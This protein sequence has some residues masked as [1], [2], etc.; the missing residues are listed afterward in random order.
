[1]SGWQTF[2]PPS[3]STDAPLSVAAPACCLQWGLRLQ[4]AGGTYEGNSIAANSRGSV[5][6]SML[7]DEVDTARMVVENKLDRPVHFLGPKE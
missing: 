7:Y 3:W 4:D 6:C 2:T 5:G 1:M